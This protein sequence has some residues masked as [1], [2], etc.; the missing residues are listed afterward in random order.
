LSAW[1]TAVS[2][3]GVSA[4]AFLVMHLAGVADI[5]DDQPC[6][7]RFT[8]LSFNASQAMAPIVLE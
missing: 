3:L 5:G 6:F 4:P 8:V 2:D 1:A 7:I